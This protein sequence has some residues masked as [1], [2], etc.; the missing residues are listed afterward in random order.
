MKHFF[1]SALLLL[2]GLS[3]SQTALADDSVTLPE[4]HAS[5]QFSSYDFDHVK[6]TG[7]YG[8]ALY[9][10][11]IGQWDKFHVGANVSFGVNAGLVDDWGCQVEFGPSVRYDLGSR[12][13]VNLPVNALC[14]ATFPEGSTST[15]TEWGLTVSPTLNAWI[16]PKFGVFAG[17]KMS[18]NFKNDATFGFVAGVSFAF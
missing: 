2:A 15:H 14:F 8:G 10:T 11:S 7:S 6:E 18:T 13:F 12:F 3:F 1:S 16:T 17:P 9:F 5:V 4:R